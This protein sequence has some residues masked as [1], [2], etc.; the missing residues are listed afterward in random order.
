MQGIKAEPK[1]LNSA[2]L[3]GILL[4]NSETQSCEVL[5]QHGEGCMCHLG[6][7][8]NPQEDTVTMPMFSPSQLICLLSCLVVATQSG[9]ACPSLL[10]AC[11]ARAAMKQE[12]NRYRRTATNISCSLP[13]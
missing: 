9:T 13:V 8:V 7:E 12:K 5:T 6:Y 4:G 10:L 3:V 1:S 2:A 11:I